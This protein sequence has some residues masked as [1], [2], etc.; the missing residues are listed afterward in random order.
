MY[1]YDYVETLWK[2]LSETGFR[3]WLMRRFVMLYRSPTTTKAILS[4]P[5]S[6]DW[7]SPYKVDRPGTLTPGHI[8]STLFMSMSRCPCP[9]VHGNAFYLCPCPDVHGKG[10]NY[11]DDVNFYVIIVTVIVLVFILV[12]SINY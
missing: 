11:H 12:L 6:T 4:S 7:I 10:E 9:D 1:D 5:F 8:F 2:C 3:C